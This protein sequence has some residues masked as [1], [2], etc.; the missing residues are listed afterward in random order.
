[1]SKLPPPNKTTVAET[2]MLGTLLDPLT[3]ARTTLH[4]YFTT[5]HP[6]QHPSFPISPRVHPLLGF[7]V[8]T[9]P[10]FR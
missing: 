9:T 1:M 4:M 8:Q 10:L 2:I 3:T 7:S 6:T 5:R